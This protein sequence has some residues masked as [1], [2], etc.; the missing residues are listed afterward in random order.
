MSSSE[1]LLERSEQL[2]QLLEILSKGR[3]HQGQ[4]AVITGEAGVGKSALLNAFSEHADG[5]VPF[6]WGHCDA[7]FTPRQLGPFYDIATAMGGDL[8]TALAADAS[9]VSLFPAVLA[10]LNEL[11]QGTVLVFEDLHWADHASLDLLKFV[12]RRLAPLRLTIC[13]SYREEDVG[14][15]HPL[16]SVLGDL[17]PERTT[18]LHLQP[19]SRRAVTQLAARK[20]FDGVSLYRATS[21]NPF[22]L[23]EILAS[24][25]SPSGPL[26]ASVRDAVLARVVRLAPAERQLL[27]GL[28]VAPDPIPMEIILQLY[29]EAGLQASSGCESL[30]LLHLEGAH[31]FRF[32]HELARVAIMESLPASERH[33][34]HQRLLDVYLSAGDDTKGDRVVHHAAALGDAKVLLEHAPRA[35][36]AAARMGAHRDAATMLAAALQFVQQASVEQAAKLYERWAYQTSL[37]QVDED[38]LEAHRQ[39]LARWRALQ[40]P[41]RVGD[42]L[43]WIWRIHWYRGEMAAAEAA[44][45]ESIAVLEAI[46]PSAELARAYALRAHTALLR[47]QREYAI[48]WGS[49]AI[50]MAGRFDDYETRVQASVTVA[51]AMVFSGD[52]EGSK[53]M[54]QALELALDHAL[55]EEAARAYTNLS[56][57]AIVTG[58]WPLAERL[59]LEGLAFDIKHSLDSWTPYLKGRHAQLRLNQGRLQEAETLAQAALAEEQSTMLMKL[60]ALTTLAAIHSRL[61]KDG[62]EERLDSLLDTVLNL[63]E[64]QRVVPVR[65]ACIEHHYLREQWDPAREQLDALLALDMTQL[66]PWDVGTLALW[67]ARLRVQ[68][69]RAQL[70]TYEH[71]QRLE[72][73]GLHHQAAAELQQG[74]RPFEAALCRLAA[75]RAG[76]FDWLAE[77]MEGF[78]A[79]G[80]TPGAEAARRLASGQGVDL[81]R[82]GTWAKKQT[83]AAKKSHPLGL[84]RKELE[85][86]SMMTEGATNAE[87]AGRLSRSQRTVEHHVSSI[88][89]K[90]NAS[91]RLEA[92]MRVIAEPWIADC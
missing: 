55:H 91:N 92:V 58:D 69:R 49:K 87:I 36:Q 86:L 39:A 85:V 15:E 77:A 42:N 40:R 10:A 2:D 64:P 34:A 67:A 8:Q 14:P 89:G 11:P 52:A 28:S 43:R 26:P 83:R 9:S 81:G 6:A 80:C 53:L 66:R 65:M 84:T 13:I 45:Q 82:S 1:S 18:R 79:L 38:V 48:Q 22:F 61:G 21:G 5:Q 32:R 57:Y 72:L 56:E 35:A 68:V 70:P 76:Q 12:A 47:A 50:S 37:F 25:E 59:V 7:L 3:S 74:G 90:L 46:P 60:P 30:G 29:G 51:T 71:A 31:G 33:A 4:I 16:T 63:G 44:A 27:H 19:L 23:S 73:E 75:A 20:G 78:S 62:A 54:S 17:P 24:G 88:L 41:D